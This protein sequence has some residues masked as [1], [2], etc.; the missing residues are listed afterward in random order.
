MSVNEGVQHW[1]IRVHFLFSFCFW[2]IKW[3][4]MRTWVI[5]R[6][7]FVTWCS[8]YQIW[9]QNITSELHRNITPEHYLKIHKTEITSIILGDL[10]SYTPYMMIA[11]SNK[12]VKRW[13]YSCSAEHPNTKRENSAAFFTTNTK[14]CSYNLLW[15]LVHRQFHNVSMHLSITSES[16]LYTTY[17]FTFFI[18]NAL[19]KKTRP[20]CIA[21]QYPSLLFFGMHLSCKGHQNHN[22]L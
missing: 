21:P 10:I 2:L 6:I 15:Y 8:K 12:Q 20:I 18:I 22:Y 5:F 13:I 14:Y 9:K 7:W 17:D 19:N 4:R 16:F 3:I 1:I 11:S